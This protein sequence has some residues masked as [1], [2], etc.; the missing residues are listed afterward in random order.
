MSE[1]AAWLLT[2]VRV[3][4]VVAFFA[5]WEASTRLGAIRPFLLPSPSIIIDELRFQFGT[6][7]LVSN[8]WLTL[9]RLFAGFLIAAAIGIPV[10]I[11]L[12]RSKFMR[13]FFDPLLSAALPMPQVAFLPV[14]ILWLGVGD[15]S[16]ISLIVFSA[17]FP[18]IVQTWAGAQ[19]IDRFIVWSAENFGVGR[20]AFVKDIVL[21]AASPQIFTGLQIA[22]PI[23]L[24]TTVVTEMLM[25]GTGVGGSII[26]GMRMSESPQLF[27]GIVAVGVVGYV[28]NAAMTRLRRRLLHWHQ[29]G[30][31]K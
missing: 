12:A 8:L 17:I 29:E 24:I 7:E 19:G 31:A 14:F 13:W 1:R 3:A 4:S 23:A 26:N 9:R 18:I 10:G 15:V 21:P 28:L 2:S 20:G 6:G 22:M 5:I 30:Q 16:K 25:G 27:A 11:A